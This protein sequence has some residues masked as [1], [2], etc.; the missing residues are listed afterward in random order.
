MAGF[1]N[2]VCPVVLGMK[3]AH[4]GKNNRGKHCLLCVSLCGC[5]FLLGRNFG[6]VHQQSVI[7]GLIFQQIL[8]VFCVYQL[9]VME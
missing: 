4:L 2:C 3:G 5:G 8:F 7:R 9:V 1:S 6:D